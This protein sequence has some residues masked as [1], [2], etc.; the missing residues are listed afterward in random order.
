MIRINLLPVKKKKQRNTAIVQLVAMVSVLLISLLGAWAWTAYYDAQVQD[1]EDQI[2]KN[3]E[4]IARLNKI[5]GEVKQL[6][7]QKKRLK[8]QL[9]VI[10]KLER[11]KTG[12]V[13]VLDDLSSYIPKRVWITSFKEKGKSLTLG[14]VGLENAD[15]SEFLRALEKSKYFSNVKLQFTES[16]S[17]GGVTIF[18]FQ[19]TCRVDYSA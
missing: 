9:D 4:E 10:K 17:Q 3:N 8:S 11:G 16:T 18:K 1:Q 5:I 19:L 13:R 6:E 14:G 7:A 15:I 2:A 12:P